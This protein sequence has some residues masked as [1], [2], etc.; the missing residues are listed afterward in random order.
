MF[1]KKHLTLQTLINH[2]VRRL[3]PVKKTFS[4]YVA[5]FKKFVD[6][7]TTSECKLCDFS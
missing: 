3:S 6:Y 2:A 7:E 1:T 4:S 5:K